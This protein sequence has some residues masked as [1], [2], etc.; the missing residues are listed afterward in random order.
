MCIRDSVKIFNSPKLKQRRSGL[1][2]NV[3]EA[4]MAEAA[5]KG[6]FNGMLAYLLKI[7]FTPTRAVDSLAIATGGATFLI[8]RTKTYLKKG[9]SKAEAD[10]KAFE[11]FAEITEKNQQSADPSKISPI[12]A[13]PLGLSLIHI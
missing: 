5:N 13:G 11:D 6:G 4:E 8:N 7:G 1:R 2:L 10:A 3:Q 12:Q 9:M